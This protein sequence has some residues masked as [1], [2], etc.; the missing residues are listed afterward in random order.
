MRIV[1]A[2]MVIMKSGPQPRRQLPTL[3]RRLSEWFTLFAFVSLSLLPLC[4]TQSIAYVLESSRWPNPSTVTFRLQL[5]APSHSLLDGSTTWN[6][7]AAPAFG[8]WNAAMRGV[9]MT[10]VSTPAAVSL[11]DGVNSVAFS[12]TMFGQSFGSGTLAV[13]YR[14][15]NQNNITVETDILF[16]KAKTFNSYRGPLRF[17]SGGYAIGDIRRVLLHELGHALGLDHPDTHGQHVAAIMNSITSN[18]ETLS[19]DDKKGVQVMYGAPSSSP[20]PVNSRLANISTRLRIGTNDDVLIGG[21]I[22]TG[23]PSKK[24][25]LRAIGPSLVAAG[26]SGALS[27]PTMELRNSS[28]ALMA[29]NDNWQQSAQSAEINASGI[30][31]T[32]ALESAIVATLAPGSYTAIVRG[33]SSTTGIGMVEGYDLAAN[34]ARLMNIATRGRVGLGDD[35]LIGGFSIQGSAGKKVLIRANGPSLTAAGV[36]GA[37]ANPFLELRNSAGTLVASNDNWASSPTAGQIS[38]TGIPPSRTEES[39]I[40]ATLAPGNYTAIVRGT[41]N[42]TGVGLVEVFDLDK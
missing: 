33:V 4:P 28:G 27:N 19:A 40:L 20:P 14:S 1:P 6:A 37:L 39:A 17:G 26:I 29:T 30:P 18:Q 35:V 22:I 15:W 7:A 3:I 38:A 10:T 21:F 16:N 2:F 25:I 31:P 5:G 24:L 23:T 8:I 41:Y 12:S 32:N 13:T 34:G 9:R 11:G 36:K 42:T